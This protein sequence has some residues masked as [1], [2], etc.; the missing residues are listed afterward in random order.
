MI[1]ILVCKFRSHLKVMNYCVFQLTVHFQLTILKYQY[2]LSHGMCCKMWNNRAVIWQ[3]IGMMLPT[4][5]RY[6]HI[7][8]PKNLATQKS[9][10]VQYLKTTFS[11]HVRR[12]HA[13]ILRYIKQDRFWIGW[14]RILTAQ[15]VNCAKWFL[16]FSARLV[17]V[18]LNNWCEI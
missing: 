15:P 13:H 9:E 10:L 7:I 5:G 3:L 17:T 4:S 8:G 16:K 11:P 12:L 2:K 14:F 18:L 1:W 6:W